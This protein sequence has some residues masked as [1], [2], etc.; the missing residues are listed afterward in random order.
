MVFKE[1][2]LTH[3]LHGCLPVNMFF[4][5]PSPN[6]FSEHILWFK[7][8]VWIGLHYFYGS[9]MILLI[10]KYSDL[11]F[12]IMCTT[13]KKKILVWHSH[14][15]LLPYTAVEEY[16]IIS[17]TFIFNLYFLCFVVD[18]IP[19]FIVILYIF[20]TKFLYFAWM[21]LYSSNSYH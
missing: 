1:V 3:L 15:F 2:N 10:F 6:V 13:D 16:F 9:L 18:K 11:V 14:N 12:A 7:F 17:F 20:L 4:T 8:A 5:F 19:A 21:W